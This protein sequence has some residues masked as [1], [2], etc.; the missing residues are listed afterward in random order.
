MQNQGGATS[1]ISVPALDLKA[2]YRSIRHEVEP[3]VLQLMESQGFIMG[4]EVVA[5]ESEAAAY[6]GAKHAIGCSSGSDALLLPLLAWDLQPGDEVITSP[7]TFFATGG[8]HLADRGASRCSS[9]STPTTYNIDPAR[10]RRR[11]SRPGRLAPSSRSTST[12]RRPT[13]TRSCE[14]ARRPRPE[15]AGRRGAGD[16]LDLQGPA[17]WARWA[18]RRRSAST[19]RRT[20]AASATPGWSRH[21]GPGD[22]AKGIARL[23]VH[24]MEPKYHHHE[25][26]FNSRID[27]LQAAVLRVKLRHLDTWTTGRRWV[28]DR[29][30]RLFAQSGLADVVTL[31]SELPGRF[32]VYNQFVVCGSPPRPATPSAPTWPRRGSARRSTTRSRSTCKPALRAWATSRA[33]SRWPRPPRTRPSLCRCTPSWPM[34]RSGMSSTRSPR[35]L[36]P[37]RSSGSSARKTSRE[38]CLT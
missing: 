23:R 3:V 18:T 17:R 9:T 13:W 5:F 35:S 6:C 14:I 4:P 21:A 38:T 20:S 33:T 34:R 26:G 19:R 31:P 7:Y 37:R 1:A 16:R 22:L 15:G 29:Y 2:Q 32:H 11:R 28:A 24:G 36:T 8:G 30:R 12:A 25:V 10:D 27:A